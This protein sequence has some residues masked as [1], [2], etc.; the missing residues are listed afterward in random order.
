MKKINKWTARISYFKVTDPNREQHQ[1]KNRSSRDA[2]GDWVFTKMSSPLISDVFVS[3]HNHLMR[4]PDKN[5]I[6]RAFKHFRLYK[7]IYCTFFFPQLSCND[8]VLGS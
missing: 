8:T 6:C 1:V 2:A 5:V 7:L 3:C 4:Q